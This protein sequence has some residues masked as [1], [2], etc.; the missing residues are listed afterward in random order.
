MRMCWR[1]VSCAAAAAL[2]G[3]GCGG[4]DNGGGSSSATDKAVVDMLTS[5]F[6]TFGNELNQT[7]AGKVKTVGVIQTSST[8]G[9][10]P[11]YLPVTVTVTFVDETGMIANAVINGSETLTLTSET[12]FNGSLNINV[13]FN[14]MVSEGYAFNGKLVY[15]GTFSGNPSTGT[16]TFNC[17]VT[18]DGFTVDGVAY[19]IHLTIDMT[20]S[21]GAAHGTVSGTINNTPINEEI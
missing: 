16:M 7:A 15:A 13:G 21:G 18:D 11:T 8:V 17:S 14:N 20:V 9:P 5:S 1:F 12:S 2:F 4:G 3:F 19:A 10:P 6:L